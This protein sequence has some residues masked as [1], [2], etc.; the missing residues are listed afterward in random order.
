VRTDDLNAPPGDA[1]KASGEGAAG[2][3]S[4][5]FAQEIVAGPSVIDEL[6]HVS[7]VAYVGWIQDV[8]KAHSA[9]VGWDSPAYFAIGAVFVVRRHEI[10][11]LAQVREGERVI[12]TTWIEKWT[13][14]T[15]E[16]HTRITKADGGAEV[17]RAKTLWA[18]IDFATGRP[19][20]VPK[21]IRDAFVNA[22]FAPRG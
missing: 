15:S 8:A 18:M 17:V 1:K 9:A 16:R 11:Y 7:N 14:V 22:G 5:S 12:L 3:A 10:E 21:E 20:R 6:A 19:R 13:A 4:P 2:P